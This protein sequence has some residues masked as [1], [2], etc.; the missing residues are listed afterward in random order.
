[1]SEEVKKKIYNL[2]KDNCPD[3]Y[4][5][6]DYVLD[7]IKPLAVKKINNCIKD[8]NT[9]AICD[10]KT[11]TVFNGNGTEPILIIGETALS[12]QPFL[13]AP[14]D[15][16]REGNLLIYAL[17]QLKVD[18]S[19]IMW[20]N[21]VN[22]FPYHKNISGT[23]IKRPPML[24]EVKE[25]SVFLDYIIRSFQPKMIII[26]GNIAL[27]TFMKDTILNVRGQKIEIKGIPAFA[28]YSPSYLIDIESLDFIDDLKNTF[29][30]DLKKAFTW[31]NLKYPDDNIFNN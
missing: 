6:I 17:E 22:C 10:N 20:T 27:N 8:C 2:V 12:T 24:T 7:I 21:T 25:C 19:K 1:M 5:P 13:S 4:N 15:S 16:S 3:D 31:F 9:C 11:K 30:D 29:I 28:T 26:L 14:F 18:T 23:K